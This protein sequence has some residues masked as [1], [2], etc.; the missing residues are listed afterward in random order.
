MTITLDTLQMDLALNTRSFRREAQG[1]F[2]TISLFENRLGNTL[3][4]F[5]QNIFSLANSFTQ[6]QQSL[7]AAGSSALNNLATP[8]AELSTEV[9]QTDG[10]MN[11]LANSANKVSKAVKGSLASF[12]QINL[13]TQTVAKSLSGNKTSSSSGKKKDE[14][15]SLN[16]PE[17]D[18]EGP[19]R[20]TASFGRLKDWLDSNSGGISNII[21]GLGESLHGLSLPEQILLGFGALISLLS[22]NPFAAFIGGAALLAA[23]IW[24]AWQNNESFR[25]SIGLLV[26][27][28]AER[29]GT[30]A[31]ILQ[32]I[33]QAFLEN[34]AQP[35][36]EVF[37]NKFSVFWEEHL[38]PFCA[39]VME[40]F[41]TLGEI[42]AGFYDKA[43]APLG[44]ALKEYF[45]PFVI[46]GI[47]TL[48]ETALG[49]AGQITD[50][51]SGI[52]TALTGVLDF[53]IGVFT[54]DWDRAW[55]GLKGALDGI[56]NALPE[57]FRASLNAT[58]GFINKLLKG[59]ERAFNFIREGL[60]SVGSA[61]GMSAI[62]PVQFYQI[63]YLATGGIVTSPTLAMLGENGKEAVLPLD[64][65]TSWLEKLSD[66]SQENLVPA[67][68]QAA[69]MIVEAIENKETQLVFDADQAAAPLYPALEREK[70]R[71]GGAAILYR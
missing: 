33:W 17:L 66:N 58:I 26:D 31:S 22:G 25:N 36:S 15:K 63:P 2:R 21:Q 8:A 6:L 14:E 32:G 34:I 19:D 28:W 52:I 48:L 68:Y 57:S 1:A 65:H 29:F 10:S 45:F 61:F 53:L 42:F 56:L 3:I 64:N 70:S 11:K 71:L 43:I 46:E 62:K 50:G 39:N 13:I 37:A 27:T 60:N 4:G 16:L 69:M 9:A 7:A 5:Q 47:G 51:L 35:L 49:C 55:D 41:G 38:Q 30:L 44:N 67:F 20:L 24:D 12:D 59:A 18:V 40:L 54:L 23:G